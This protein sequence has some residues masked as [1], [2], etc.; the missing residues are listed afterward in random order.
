M[1]RIRNSRSNTNCK[2]T[3]QEGKVTSSQVNFSTRVRDLCWG[4][5]SVPCNGSNFSN[6]PNNTFSWVGNRR[7]EDITRADGH[8]DSCSGNNGGNKVENS[9]ECS[10]KLHD[11][12]ELRVGGVD[13]ND[14]VGL[15]SLVSLYTTSLAWVIN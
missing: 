4:V 8:S 13:D 3:V 5:G 1:V 9:C 7:G 15:G 11:D 2:L 6:S 14:D 10:R 12:R